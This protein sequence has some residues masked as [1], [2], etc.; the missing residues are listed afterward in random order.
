MYGTKQPGGA[1]PFDYDFTLLLGGNAI[2]QILTVD[3]TPKGAG[4]NLVNEG[5]GVMDN[6]VRIVWSGG[7]D[8][9]SYATRVQVRDSANFEHEIDGEIDVRELAFI[10]PDIDPT[11]SPY[12][13]ADEY[14]LRYGKEEAVR[15]TDEARTGVV[16]KGKLDA[17]LFDATELTESFLGT[18]YQLPLA[19]VPPI[20][21]GIVADLARERLHGARPLPQVTANADRAR[22]MLRDLSAGRMVLQIATGETVD[23][24]EGGGPAT[25]PGLPGRVF[26]AE[27]LARF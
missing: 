23:A 2:A 13:S 27:T 12:L 14:V 26:D 4:A 15:L 16:D 17:A 6:I 20:I 21:Q 19:S 25:A 1:E 8:G 7:V 10:V 11:R 5:Q 3:S 24:K 9:E 22:Q 18:R